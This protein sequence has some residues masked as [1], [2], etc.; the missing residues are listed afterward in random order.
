MYTLY[1]WKFRQGERSYM[2]E[3]YFVC[4]QSLC[5]IFRVFC[6]CCCF[7]INFHQSS[8]IITDFYSP[9]YKPL[10]KIK[11]VPCQ[12]RKNKKRRTSNIAATAIFQYRKCVRLLNQQPS[13]FYSLNPI[14]NISERR[15]YSNYHF[16]V[17]ILAAWDWVGGPRLDVKGQL[18]VCSPRIRMEG[19]KLV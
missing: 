15:V 5:L 6:I 2:V 16:R 14:K 17:Q 9:F 10:K 1:L 11:S 3:I 19:L 7:F 12:G 4:N 13:L 18:I 8:Q